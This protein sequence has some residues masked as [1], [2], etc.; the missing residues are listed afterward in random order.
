MG[1]QVLVGTRKGLF[2][3]VRDG[4]RWEV[5][6]VDFLGVPVPM[7]LADRRDGT[8]YAAVE[9]GHFGSKL[10]A[11]VDGGRTWEERTCPAYPPKPPEAPEVVCPMR[12]K[13]VPWTLE[14]IWSLECGGAAEPGTLWCGTIPGGLFRSE[15]GGRSWNLNRFLWD[16][17]ER[18]RWF[19]GG[20]DWPGIHSIL[21]D[22]ADA[23]RVRIAISCGGVWETVDGGG[24]WRLAGQGLEADYMPPSQAMD[25]SVQDPHRAVHCA[26]HPQRAWIQH[27]SGIFRSDDGGSNWERIRTV[28]PDFGFVVV[29]HPTDPDTAWFVPGVKDDRRVPADGVL[30]VSRTRDGGRTFER[31]WRGLP[32]SHAYHLVYRHGM[33]VD[34]TGAHLVMGS[35]TGSVWASANGGDDWERISAELPPVYCVRFVED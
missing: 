27:H 32:Q 33:D 8:W 7:V 31:L 34:R 22:P 29:A 15:D 10:Q 14:K 23:R 35:T 5:R 6:S 24:T 3:L 20:Y 19:G 9:H 16:M 26:G 2:T 28:Q 1:T 30:A 17:P 11:T 25:P 18:G 21:V 4:G 12:N 13:P